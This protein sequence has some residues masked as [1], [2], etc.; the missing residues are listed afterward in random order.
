VRTPFAP[1]LL[2]D[3]VDHVLIGAGDIGDCMT[4]GAEQTAILLGLAV[5]R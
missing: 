4:G 5:R 3:G 2:F 1:S